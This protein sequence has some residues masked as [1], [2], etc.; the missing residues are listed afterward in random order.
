[1]LAKKQKYYRRYKRIRSKIKGTLKQPRASVFR[2]AKHIYVQLI[3]D[4][5]AKVIAA[6]S[7]LELKKSKQTKLEQAKKVGK[8]IAEKAKELK[9]EKVVFCKGGYK[10]HG[11]VKSL[12]EGMREGGLKF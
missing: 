5:K 2:S 8:L 3:N 1:M 9:I 11:R 4:E 10:Y 12:A 6:A 7:D